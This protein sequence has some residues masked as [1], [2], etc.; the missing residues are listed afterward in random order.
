MSS[1]PFRLSIKVKNI[2]FVKSYNKNIFITL[3]SNLN[4]N[5]VKYA[6]IGDY[7][8]LPESVGHDIDFWTNNV[9][10]FRKA[11]F[12]T[13][14]TIGFKIIIDNKTANGCNVA[15][16]KR[17]GDTIY[18]MKLDVMVDTSWKSILT[19]VDR[20]VMEENIMPFKDFYVANP[21]SEAV[22]HFLYPMFEWGKIKKETYK[23]DIYRYYKGE[24]FK[25]VFVKLWGNYTA[26]EVWHLIAEKKWDKIQ[27]RM[28]SLK[29][30]ALFKGL[31]KVCTYRNIMNATYHVINRKVRPSG[32]VLAFCGLD[33][34]GKT[35]ILDE[36]NDMFVNLLKS[37]KVFYGYWRPY[38]IPEIR[39]LFGKK[40]SKHGV[41]KQAQ[42]GVTVKEPEKKP[43]NKII[44]IVKLLYYWLDYML[45]GK[46]YDTIHQRG[47]MVLFDRHYIDMAVHPQRFEMGLSRKIILFLYRFIP[48]AD[49]TFFL[50][51]T[52]EEIL[53]RK[54]E[55]TKEEISQ[56]TDDYI[57]VGRKIKNFI[58][59]HTNTTIAEEID[60][61]LT[62]IAIR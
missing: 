51:C 27:K 53:K 57:E 46:K 22:M 38:V 20:G 45:A 25:K 18:L 55:F 44:S 49:Y 8:N 47:G 19:L 9:T 39:E 4:K 11:L 52:P 7:H 2:M 42:K 60:E 48:K 59:I 23:E 32:K 17:E 5:S 41:D 31:F 16:Y 56:M 54:E 24:T 21:E 12:E 36:M 61:I 15:I 33:G 37:K 29:K 50:Y 28:D 13:I 34:A 14:K 26:D 43:K 6:V 40:N 30:K 58:P 62:H 10:S 1:L 35:T 3:I